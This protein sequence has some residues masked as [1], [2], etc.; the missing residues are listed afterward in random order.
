M[1]TIE[2]Y[3]LPMARWLVLVAVTLEMYRVLLLALRM[4]ARG[5]RVWRVM[6]ELR[7]EVFLVG[8]FL[9]YVN[10]LFLGDP[11]EPSDRRELIAINLL[12]ALYFLTMLMGR[13]TNMARRQGDPL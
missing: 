3:V 6:H 12:Y 9:F 11:T 10:A 8:I 4:Y 7:A 2:V 13:Y 1:E 5:A